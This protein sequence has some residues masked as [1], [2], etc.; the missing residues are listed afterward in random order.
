MA[1]GRIG[2]IQVPY[3]P[4]QCEA[5]RAILPLANKLGSGSP[6][7]APAPRG[8]ARAS[9]AKPGRVRAIASLR[10]HHLA[11]APDQ[12]RMSDPRIPVSLAAT[13]PSRPGSRRTP[14]RRVAAIV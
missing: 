12:W 14:P 10:R 8:A 13:A 5:E 6:A 9:A 1:T 7:H 3:N 2:T 4:V 11:Q